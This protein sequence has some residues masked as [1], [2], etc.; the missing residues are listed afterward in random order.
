MVVAA[1]VAAVTS[2]AHAQ[3]GVN[4][5]S[6]YYNTGNVGFR[7]NTPGASAHAIS[8][9][10]SSAIAVLGAGHAGAAYSI[11]V[12]GISY[13]P[14]GY[15]GLFDGGRY[16]ILTR[17]QAASGDTYALWS[18][19]TSPTGY[20]GVFK[21]G[22]YGVYS[23]ATAA[24]AYAGYFL[25]RAY[26]STRVGVGTTNPLYKLHVVDTATGVVGVASGT[27]GITNGVQGRANSPDGFG[28]YGTTSATSGVTAG[29]YGDCA[30]ATTAGVAGDAF[31]TSGENAGVYGRT[32]SPNGWGVYCE[33]NL[34]ASGFK[35]FSIDH[36]LDPANKYLNHFSAEGPEALLIYRGNAILDDDGAAWIELPS[37]FDAINR[38]VSYQLT[39]V[40]AP[41]PM[42]HVAE[43]VKANR[44][45]VAGGKPGQKVCWTVTGA[46]N[47]AYARAYPK[48]VE[49]EKSAETRGTYIHPQLYGMPAQTGRS[50]RR[51]AAAQPL[52]AVAQEGLRSTVPQVVGDPGQP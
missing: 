8:A 21:G 2:A 23:E 3:W 32:G 50:F 26:F 46:R 31:H 35:N 43:E 37:Y 28:V 1:C 18:Q 29:V 40:G 34:G 30:G 48:P 45:K 10:A 44:F 49:Q 41:A 11:G 42:L 4:G 51:A 27:S 5:S 22:R 47:D 20:A 13:A 52:N 7:T 9:Q 19:V 38:D 33:G 16:G 25:G 17:A 15:G 39:A 36:P 6:I 14:T 12:R 24:N